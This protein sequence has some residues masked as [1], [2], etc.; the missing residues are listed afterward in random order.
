MIEIIQAQERVHLP[1]I[2]ELFWEYLQWANA[3]LNVEFGVDFDI[4][5]M[6]EQDMVEL[7]KFLPPNGRLLLGRC[8]GQLAGIACMRKLNKDMG[9]VKRMYVRSTIRRR[10]VGQ[11]L[12]SR[13]LDEARAIGYQR[14]RLDSARFMK[15]AH[16][17]YRSYGFREIEP[18]EGSEIPNE[19]QV[20]WIFM[21]R[22]MVQG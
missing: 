3:R 8:D 1:R 5:E 17:L 10:G 4:A 18:Y 6:L 12:L 2:H 16:A 14:V 22:E 9:E 15:E 11:A 21:E 20:H 7:G 13:L 19:F